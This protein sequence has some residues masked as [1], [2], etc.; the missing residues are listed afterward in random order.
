MDSREN[1]NNKLNNNSNHIIRKII[2]DIRNYKK[3]DN[4]MLEEINNLNHEDLMEIIKTY[5]NIIDNVNEV[6]NNLN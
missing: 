3:F 1:K 2:H 6:L 5:N 4:D